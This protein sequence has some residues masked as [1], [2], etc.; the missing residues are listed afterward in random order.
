MKIKQ[1]IL[2][3]FLSFSIVFALNLN[4]L[5][6]I[7]GVN[8][9]PYELNNYILKKGEE[10]NIPPIILKAILLKEGQVK[11]KWQQYSPDNQYSHG[12]NTPAV[13]SP[14]FAEEGGRR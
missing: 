1:V 14:L 6:Q 2:G 9:T 11:H 10:N 8:P 5:R 12:T 13:E 4:D 7:Q 3:I